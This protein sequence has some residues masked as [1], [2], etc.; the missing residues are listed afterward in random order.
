MGNSRPPRADVDLVDSYARRLGD[1]L[2]VVLASPGF[3]L[4]ED[5]EVILRR[6]NARHASVP[7]LVD[8]ER[9]RRVVVRFPRAELSDGTWVL[10][11][12]ARNQGRD[13]GCRLLVQ[14]ARPLVLLWGSKALPSTL[15][16]PHPRPEPA[17]TPTQRARATVVRAGSAVSR[18]VLRSR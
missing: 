18:R 2:E 5:T 1:E 15:P 16:V 12:R 8:D 7:S 11:L 13:L 4:T 10:R 14:G 3:D 9:G 17:R 6:R